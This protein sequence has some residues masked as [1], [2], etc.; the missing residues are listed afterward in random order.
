MKVDLDCDTV[1]VPMSLL[2]L[3][4]AGKRMVRKLEM[5]L[6]PHLALSDVVPSDSMPMNE[7]S[8]EG[9]ILD[10]FRDFVSE[11]IEGLE[12][13]C[14]YI[15]D[16]KELIIILDE[17]LF[18]ASKQSNNSLSLL[19]AREVE[20]TKLF[21]RSQCASNYFTNKVLRIYKENMLG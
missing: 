15:E 8:S 16:E 4:K 10:L 12:S 7:N 3:L 20:F 18:V 1:E 5:K 2:P 17:R 13:C 6:R 11:L 19:S 14:I 9:S 21:L